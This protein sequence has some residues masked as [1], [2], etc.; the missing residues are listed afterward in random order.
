MAPPMQPETTTVDRYTLAGILA[1]LDLNPARLSFGEQADFII[2]RLSSRAEDLSEQAA[3]NAQNE[4][5]TRRGW[6][7]T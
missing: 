1:E 7:C 5:A 2:D 6:P 3:I 4:V